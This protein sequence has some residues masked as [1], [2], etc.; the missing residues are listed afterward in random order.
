MMCVEMV[1][2]DFLSLLLFF[3]TLVLLVTHFLKLFNQNDPL[4]HLTFFL[5][6][7]HGWA[8]VWAIGWA[9]VVLDPLELEQ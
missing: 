8:I 3:M 5:I 4:I 9:S 6:S 1:N 2:W 7:A